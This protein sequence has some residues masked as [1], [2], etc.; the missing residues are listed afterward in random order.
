MIHIVK[1]INNIYSNV[2]R[3]GARS[4]N[5]ADSTQV[6]VGRDTLLLY[7]VIHFE[8]SVLFLTMVTARHFESPAMTY[9]PLLILTLEAL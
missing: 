9:L 8:Q 3:E 2:T 7:Y 5:I 4:G 6:T 1:L